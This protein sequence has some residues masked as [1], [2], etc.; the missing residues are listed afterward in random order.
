MS[1]SAPDDVWGWQNSPEHYLFIG[2]AT[3]SQNLPQNKR[4]AADI[5]LLTYG[6][7]YMTH[8]HYFTWQLASLLHVSSDSKAVATTLVWPQ[9]VPTSQW[10]PVLSSG[11]NQC[12]RH[13]GRQYFL[14]ATVSVHFTVVASTLVWPQSVPTSQWSPV[15]SS[16]YS[17]CPWLSI[18][19]LAANILL[20][21][22]I[23]NESVENV[24]LL[25]ADTW[26]SN[27][28]FIT[29]RIPWFKTAEK[30]WLA[31]VDR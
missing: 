8:G 23:F 4:N 17:Q 21:F 2:L 19:L 9:S 20:L 1:P 14:L 29:C 27:T 22:T 31:T 24:F 13:S 11:H 16:G 30:K 6:L 18:P 15:L 26:H 7:H 28:L 12:P 3:V 10:S 5:C 25:P